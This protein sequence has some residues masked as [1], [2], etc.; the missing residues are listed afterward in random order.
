MKNWLVAFRLRTLPLA[1]SSIGMGAFMAAAEGKFDLAIFSLCASTTIFLQILSNL[2]NDYGDTVN[3][4]DHAERSGPS[5]MVQ[6]GAITLSQMKTAMIIFVVLSLFSGLSLLF[7][8]FGFDWKAFLFFLAVGLG[9]IVAAVAYTAGKRPYGYIGLGDLSVFIF[10]GIVGV[11]GSNYLFTKS[12]HLDLLLPALSCGLFSVG[13]LNINN[14]R[15]IESDKKAG[16]FSV[17]VRIGRSAAVNY[18]TF[19]ILLGVISAAV[20]SFINYISPL[21]FL[22]VVM[23]P[24]FGVNIKAVKNKTESEDLDPYLKQLALSTMLFVILFG[25]GQYPF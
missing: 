18:H 12:F 16:K 19:I 23:L 21:Q 2:A 3:G 13:V 25:I 20:Y 1:L 15:D 9:A 5:R 11:V 4:A 10:F 7:L 17:P 24:L 6:T 22:F 8:A 14:I